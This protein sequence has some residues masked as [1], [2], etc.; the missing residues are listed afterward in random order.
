MMKIHFWDTSV[1]RAI[2][3]LESDV[4]DES[5]FWADESDRVPEQEPTEDDGEEKDDDDGEVEEIVGD[6]NDNV[7]IE[8]VI[9]D[10]DDA[11][12]DNLMP[13]EPC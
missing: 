10:A 2:F 4:G 6:D 8:P 11:N 1:T 5:N 13:T 7:Q 12:I 9:D 3:F